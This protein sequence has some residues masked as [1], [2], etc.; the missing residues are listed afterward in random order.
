MYFEASGYYWTSGNYSLSS[1]FIYHFDKY[2]REDIII[3]AA[4]GNYRGMLY[5]IRPQKEEL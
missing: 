3:H 5:S 4:D 1:G 2:K